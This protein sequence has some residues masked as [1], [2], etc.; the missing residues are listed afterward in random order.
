M[1][2]YTN[3]TTRTWHLFLADP[4]R[5]ALAG[6]K[7]KLALFHISKKCPYA[8]RYCYRSSKV[9]GQIVPQGKFCLAGC[10][11]HGQ[12]IF[13]DADLRVYGCLTQIEPELCIG[14]ISET[15]E[16]IFNGRNPMAEFDRKD[17]F[18]VQYMRS[19]RMEKSMD[20]NSMI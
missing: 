2:E 12:M 11:D 7:I 10:G 3:H 17:C 1:A 15:G 18:M 6:K 16:L 9:D 20:V 4:P 8:C 19:Q 5:L 14:R 13:I